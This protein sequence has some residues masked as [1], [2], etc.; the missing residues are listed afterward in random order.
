MEVS[1]SRILLATDGSEGS[2]KAGKF[3][4][5]IARSCGASL[6]V[7]V[8][9]D[10]DALLMNTVGASA[11]PAAVPNLSIDFSE[12]KKATEKSC[13]DTMLKAAKEQLVDCPDVAT[14]QIWGH[15]AE[16]ICEYA[17]DNEYDLIVIGSRGRS[18][19]KRLLLGS[20]SMQVAQHAPCPVTIVH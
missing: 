10:E 17:R 18:A 7:L 9:H 4:A 3:A 6:M 15:I 5:T 13:E 2:V 19:F 12:I 8:A 20:V 11:W 16:A 1:L 14:G